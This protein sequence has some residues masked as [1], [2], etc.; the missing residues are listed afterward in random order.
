VHCLSARGARTKTYRWADETW[1][2]KK[3][4]YYS[5]TIRNENL[6]SFENCNILLILFLPTGSRMGHGNR[7]QGNPF[8]AA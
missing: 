3:D 7:D 8:Q 2:R 5:K 1:T 4:M 6:R